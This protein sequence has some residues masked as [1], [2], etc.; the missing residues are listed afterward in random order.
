[1]R[2]YLSALGCKLNQNEMET[3]A[4]QLAAAGHQVVPD[5]ATADTIIVNTCT[6]THVAARKSR[7]LTRRLH[8]A[9]RNAR[10]VLTGCFAEMARD[11]AEE[12]PGVLQVVGNPDKDNLIHLLGLAPEDTQATPSEAGDV[13]AQLRTRASVKIQDGCDNECTYC[14]V[15][16]ARGPQRSRS[17]VEILGEIQARL[18]AGYQEIVLT[19]VHIGAY[20]RDHGNSA[21]ATLWGLVEE[22]LSGTNVARLRLS[23]IEPW[24]IAPESLRLWEDRRLCRHLHLPLQSGSN[25]VLSRMRRHYTS[26]EFARVVDS[27]RSVVPELAITTD[28]IVGFPGETD[29]EFEETLRF[30][31][32]MQF[33]KVHIF[34]F[35]SREGTEAAAYPNQVEPQVKRERVRRLAQIAGQSELAFRKQLVNRT[36]EVLWETQGAPGDWLGL[37]DHYVRVHAQSTEDLRNTITA[38]RVTGLSATGLHGIILRGGVSP[39]PAAARH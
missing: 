9:N 15:R 12:L 17:R 19:G 4:R 39:P 36:V 38:V 32:A 10:I 22:I 34:P 16:V 14:I 23:S 30:V 29:A 27:A 20:G 21:P 13:D 18:Q 37:T 28:V 11:E 7:Q 2:V 3:L 26:Q 6:V 24:D 1:M 5:A 31:E 35:S 25:A 33:R 8:R